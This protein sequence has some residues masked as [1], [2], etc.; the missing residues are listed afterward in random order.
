[1]EYFT[2]NN[3]VHCEVM[4]LPVYRIDRNTIAGYPGHPKASRTHHN[5]FVAAII[6]L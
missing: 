6:F 1:M 4:I 2:G 5:I 3:R